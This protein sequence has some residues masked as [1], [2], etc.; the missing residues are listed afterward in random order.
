MSKKSLLVALLAATAMHMGVSEVSTAQDDKSPWLVRV[1]LI[2]IVPDESS[3]VSIGGEATASNTLV[4]ELDI[5]YFWSDHFATELILATNRHN[6][7]ARG[8]ALGDL[9]LGKV[10]LLPPT[11][12]AQYHFAPDSQ[13]RPYVGAGINYTIFYDDEPGDVNSISYEDSF[14]FA[15]QAGVDIGLSDNWAVNLDVKKLYLNTDVEIN[16]GGVTADVDLDPW[17]FGAGLAYR[18]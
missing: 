10:T 7:G 11:L 8:T 4:P 1:R 2:D 16:G 5:T 14:G 6:I 13:I 18:F 15:L 3:T 9:S 17:I 12:L